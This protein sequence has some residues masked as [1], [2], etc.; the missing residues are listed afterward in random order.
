ME[1]FA[2]E[3]AE[4][5]YWTR[6]APGIDQHLTVKAHRILRPLVAARGLQDVGVFGSVLRW[7]N[8]PGRFGVQVEGKW[9][10]TFCWIEGEGPFDIRF[11]RR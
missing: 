9:H 11:E 10:L 4:E 7:K 2:D 1:R 3:I 6:F 5:I 8:A